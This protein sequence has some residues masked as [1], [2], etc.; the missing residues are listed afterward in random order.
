[1]ARKLGF[2]NIIKITVATAGCNS[3][4][5]STITAD[6]N[7]ASIIATV[8]SEHEQEKSNCFRSYFSY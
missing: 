3:V 7:L 6:I 4:E 1:M 2:F 5:E 8:V